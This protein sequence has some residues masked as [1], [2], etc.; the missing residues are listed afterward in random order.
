MGDDCDVRVGGYGHWCL[1]R[2]RQP[3]YQGTSRSP[4]DSG[5]TKIVSSRYYSLGSRLG[6]ES[7][8]DR[9]ISRSKG[10]G[11][12]EPCTRT[13]PC[14]MRVPPY[15]LAP[16]LPV[17]CPWKSLAAR[18]H[19]HSSSSPKPLPHALHWAHCRQSWSTL[20]VVETVH[21]FECL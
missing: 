2:A 3:S 14:I 18:F 1:R 10:L 11:L 8:G 6:D 7:Q 9:R 21:S 13:G 19:H 20:S 12:D 16:P 17:A 15:N 4:I 5:A